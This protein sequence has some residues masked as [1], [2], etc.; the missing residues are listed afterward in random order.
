VLLPP[1]SVKAIIFRA[2]AKF[3]GQ[4]PATKHE[5]NVFIKSSSEMNAQNPRLGWGE[6]GKAI[7]QVSI[8]VFFRALSKYFFGQRWLS[9]PE[10]NWPVR[11]C[12]KCV[13]KI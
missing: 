13:S 8:S 3:F 5:K 4:K 7:L 1:E 10:K 12:L 11:L 2:N 6:S 9:P